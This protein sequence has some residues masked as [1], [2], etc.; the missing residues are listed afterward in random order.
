MHVSSSHKEWQKYIVGSSLFKTQN[1]VKNYT[2]CVF[3]LKD[4]GIRWSFFAANYDKDFID[5]I[6]TTIELQDIIGDIH[7]SDVVLAVL[8]EYKNTQQTDVMRGVD[9]LITRTREM[10]NADY[11][12]FLKRWEELSTTN[13]KQK[14]LTIIAS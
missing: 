12:R 3:L 9:T 1:G 4:F 8:T 5:F 10:R 13:F 2:T 6:D 11:E 7:D 14:L